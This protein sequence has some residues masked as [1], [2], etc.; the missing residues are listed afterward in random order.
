MWLRIWGKSSE[1]RIF[2]FR[3]L[4]TGFESWK[5]AYL[6]FLGVFGLSL[7]AG[8]LNEKLLSGSWI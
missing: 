8:A 1:A 6:I 5:R 4:G 7:I 2:S 3:Y